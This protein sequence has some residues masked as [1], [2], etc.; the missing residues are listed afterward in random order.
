MKTDDDSFVNL[1]G[2]TSHPPLSQSHIPLQVYL[3]E[4]LVQVIHEHK[5]EAH[6]YWGATYPETDDRLEMWGSSYLLSM[7]L[8]QW[9]STSEIPPRDT[10]GFEDAKVADWLV[11]R[12]FRDNWLK[13]NSAFAGYP[14]PDLGD[15]WYHQENE[16]RPF[17]RWTII[18]HP[19]KEDFMW[20]EAAN[21]YLN[22]T[23]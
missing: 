13:N 16:V 11:A 7:D 2:N 1:P 14:W 12:G 8:V 10:S 4:A 22:L 20:I 23:W 15:H 19:L 6:L 5:D 21:Y 17:D 3:F 9:I 18:T